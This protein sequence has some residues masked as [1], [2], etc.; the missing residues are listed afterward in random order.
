MQ[1]FTLKRADPDVFKAEFCQTFNKE[2]QLIALKLKKIET[3]E[4][5]PNVSS[6]CYN[7]KIYKPIFLMNMDAK[8]LNKNI[9]KPNAG[10]YQ[11]DFHTIKVD[12]S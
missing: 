2:L 10:I 12:S 11:K 7:S 3:N 4:I 8:T 6:Y 9:C 5:L 1:T